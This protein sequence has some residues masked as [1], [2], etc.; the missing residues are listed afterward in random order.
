MQRDVWKRRLWSR[1]GGGFEDCRVL[2]LD[3]PF[4]D[5]LQELR[6]E[7]VERLRRVNELDLDRKVLAELEDPRGVQVMIRTEARDALRH[8]RTGNTVVEE[9]VQHGEV[10][11]LAVVVHVLSHVH[12]HS[13]CRSLCE[14]T[15][16]RL[17]NAR[18]AI[19]P[20]HSA[21]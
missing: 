4:A 9:I 15:H 1:R 3:E 2:H 19:T 13:L 10:E 6:Q 18:A 21:R 12:R 16:P 5:H 7:G 11:R 8:G 17:Q 20:P 14:H